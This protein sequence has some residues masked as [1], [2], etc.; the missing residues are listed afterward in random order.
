MASWSDDGRARLR[1]PIALGRRAPRLGT[2]P[3]AGSLSQAEC[4]E[5]SGTL[6]GSSQ[7][8]VPER[9]REVRSRTVRARRPAERSRAARQSATARGRAQLGADRQHHSAR[10]YRLAYRLTGNR[11]DAEDLTQEVFVRVFRSL[12][13]YTPGTF[14]GWLHRITTNLFLDQARR[15]S[16]SGSTRSPTSRL[17]AAQRR[18]DARRGVRR[19]DVRRRHRGRPGRPAAGLPRRRGAVRRRGADL[20]GDRRHP[21]RQDRH[22]PLPDPPR[23]VD[24]A[25]GPGPPRAEGGPGAL[26]RP[27]DRRE[28]RRGGRPERPPR[29]PRQR[30]RRRPALRRGGG[31]GL[32]AR[33]WP[34]PPAASWW[35]ARAG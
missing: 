21:R 14:E 8:A 3:P 7:P 18:A 11:H 10:V 28:Q 32:G 19:P 6:T 4:S 20:R 27:G 2:P 22:R 29:R 16:G 15:K 35:S 31:A 30:P 24:A 34:A 12:D 17:P 1:R 26:R 23:P 25:H 13:T 5:P 33:A 9:A